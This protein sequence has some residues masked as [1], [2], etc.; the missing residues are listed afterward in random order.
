MGTDKHVH[1]VHVLYT[2]IHIQN[3]TL[4][5]GVAV[6]T[7]ADMMIHPWG[8]LLIG[9]VAAVLSV[10]G[11]TFVTVLFHYTRLYKVSQSGMQYCAQQRKCEHLYPAILLPKSQKYVILVCEKVTMCN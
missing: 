10:L 8:A 2:Q 5:G 11:Y 3:A 7:M 9:S 6:G 4:A 1:S